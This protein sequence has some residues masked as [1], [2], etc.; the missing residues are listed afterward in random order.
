MS[1]SSLIETLPGV[2]HFIV[3]DN[4]ADQSGGYTMALFSLFESREAFDIFRR[5][6]S[7]Q[8]VWESKLQQVVEER[9]VAEGE[10]D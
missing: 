5:H 3:T 10:Q 2:M 8:D 4:L 1:N 9:I 6:P 7:Y